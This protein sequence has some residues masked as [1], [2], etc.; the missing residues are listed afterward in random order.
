MQLQKIED[1]APEILE[2]EK[3]KEYFE[4]G[5]R[6][7]QALHSHARAS[8]SHNV[9]LN[10]IQAAAS[11]ALSRDIPSFKYS[12]SRRPALSSSTSYRRGTT[13]GGQPPSAGAGASHHDVD[14]PATEYKP[15]IWMSAGGGI[16]HDAELDWVSKLSPADAQA[17]V[18]SLG[19]RWGSM[20]YS[21]APTTSL[22]RVDLKPM[23]IPLRCKKSKRCPK[24]T[25]ILIKPELKAQSVKYKIKLVAINY[26]PSLEVFV[27]G[28]SAAGNIKK[29]TGAKDK[30]AS[31]D[32]GSMM[33]PGRTYPFHLIFSNPLYDPITVRVS[34]Q[35]SL[36]SSALP[37]TT[38]TIPEEAPMPIAPQR[39][40]PYAVS[41][42]TTAFPIA[43]FAEAWEY[44]DDEEM[45]DEDELGLGGIS[46]NRGH[47]SR[48]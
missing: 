22:R 6:A 33:L 18:S 3:L 44:E 40:P 42:P 20:Q 37:A 35:R 15:R 16:G 17:E 12:S 30:D 36:P 13:S 46:M 41:L 28:L 1:S 26:L 10:P 48:T 14:D 34:I 9:S 4:P 7:A 47:V 45:F 21:W 8:A 27:P 38:N 23:R 24:C 43:A 25:H 39:R 2:L 19:Q 31:E 29:T 32:I 11:N 5:L